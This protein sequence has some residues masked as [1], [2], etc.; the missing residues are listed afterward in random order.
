[1]INSAPLQ[2]TPAS[3]LYSESAWSWYCLGT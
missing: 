1:M 3:D 2:A